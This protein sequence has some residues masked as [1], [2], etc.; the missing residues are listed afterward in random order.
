MKLERTQRRNFCKKSPLFPHL[1]NSL[2]V[3]LV[4]CAKISQRDCM[5]AL[6]SR[7]F[8]LPVLLVVLA[9]ASICSLQAVEGEEASKGIWINRADG[10]KMNLLV[11]NNN[12][13]L[14]FYN[15]EQEQVE[16]DAAQAI[17]H[18]T[19][20]VIQA[21]ETLALLPAQKKEHVILTSPRS[22]RPPYQYE[23]LLVLNFDE[24]DKKTES[25]HLI[26][27]QEPDSAE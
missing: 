2:K 1:L 24:P 27:Q 11:E 18:Y 12:F 13:E 26:F 16:P 14:H 17:V 22:I 4:R 5:K 21:R 19:S 25:H 6:S 8:L 9:F 20:R 23:V 15:E 7:P 10:G 3:R